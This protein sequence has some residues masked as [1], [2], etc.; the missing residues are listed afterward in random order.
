[1]CDALLGGVPSN[2]TGQLSL[3]VCV[4]CMPECHTSRGLVTRDAGSWLVLVTR[5]T[6]NGEG[7]VSRGLSTREACHQEASFKLDT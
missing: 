1:M 3:R 2:A 4:C 5:G 6:E 7:L